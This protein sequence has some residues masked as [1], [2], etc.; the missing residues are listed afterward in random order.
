MY[1]CLG[2]HPLHCTTSCSNTFWVL[3][4][5]ICVLGDDRLQPEVMEQH[6]C[7]PKVDQSIVCF[8]RAVTALELANNEAHY[9]TYVPGIDA[10]R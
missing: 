2:S 10:Y 7:Q 8:L 5:L 4:E 3:Q 1:C 6:L 9:I